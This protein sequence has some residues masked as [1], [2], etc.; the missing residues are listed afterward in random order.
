MRHDGEERTVSRKLQSKARPEAYQVIKRVGD[1]NYVL[2]DVATGMEIK[3]FKQPVHADRWWKPV[4]FRM[5]R[6]STRRYQ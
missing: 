1:A 4:S 3:A 2:G 5:L 6:V